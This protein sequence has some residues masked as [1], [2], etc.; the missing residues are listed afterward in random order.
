MLRLPLAGVVGLVFALGRIAESLLLTQWSLL[1]T[2]PMVRTVDAIFWG[3]LA[4]GA[5]WLVLGWAARQE[6]RFRNVQARMLAALRQSNTNLE[7]L[8]E[9]NQRLVTRTTLDEICDYAISLPGRVL[10]AQ[11]AALVLRDEN[12][13]PLTV[14][15]VGQGADVLTMA[16]QAFAIGDAPDTFLGPRVL[17]PATNPA[18]FSMCILLPL[19]E[20][21]PGSDNG[22]ASLG[23]IEAYLDVIPRR[24]R[25]N[26]SGGDEVDT[27]PNGAFHLTSSMQS[28]LVTIA[29]ELTEAI[30]GARRRARELASLAALEQAITEERTRIARDLHDGIAQSLAFMRMRVDLWEDWLEQD[31]QRLHD[32]FTSFKAN[33]RTQ[34]EELRRAIFALRPV[35]LSQLG[36]EGALRRFVSDFADQ[37]GWN[38]E[39]ELGNIPHELPLPLE[40]ASFRVVQEALNNSAKH[41]RAHNVHITMRLVDGGLQ[42]VVRDDG[43][44]FDPNRV[45][46]RG[47]S[48]GL[49]QM[50]ERVAALDGQFTVLSRPGQG[51]ELRIWLPIVYAVEMQGLT[52]DD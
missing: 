30:L 10:E 22:T 38:L 27:P 39:L 36:F 49:R 48:L 44:G 50:R 4:A 17:L 33:L 37:Q 35:E 6:R 40:L 43:M 9:I 31:P 23:W 52:I 3:G 21:G 45:A 25:F 2:D 18:P 12:R 26:S 32:E 5:V 42:I 15:C 19:V 11:A 7:L 20:A 46:E 34:I 29:G 16:R 51:T 8:N 24:S 14:R 13:A 41:A 28:L 1:A 47:S